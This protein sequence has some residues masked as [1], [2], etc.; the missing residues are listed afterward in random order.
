MNLA[1]DPDELIQ[2]LTFVMETG[3]SGWYLDRETGDVLLDHEDGEELPEDF[4][5]DPRYINIEALPSYEEFGVMEEFLDT[6]PTGRVADDLARA[7]AGRKPFRHFKDVLFDYP[8]AR[9]AWFAFRDA[10]YLRLAAEWCEDHGIKP[11]W[12]GRDDGGKG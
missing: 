12:R 1:I 11:V 3:R 2:A 7:L 8:D 9:Q 5:D 6:L 10:A 4:E